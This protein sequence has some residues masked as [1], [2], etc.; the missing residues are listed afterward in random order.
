MHTLTAPLNPYKL[1]ITPTVAMP[2][3]NYLF[4]DQ[5]LAALANTTFKQ[6]VFYME[7]CESGSMF[8][9]LPNDTSIY[10]LTASNADE[11]SWGCYCP[12]ND[13]INGTSVGS[14]LGD[15]FS[16][17]WLENIDDAAEPTNINETLEV[18][19]NTLYVEVNLSHASQFGDASFRSV[20]A[21]A[22]FLAAG[23]AGAAGNNRLAAPR[24]P[25]PWAVAS[26][27]RATLLSL[28]T[29]AARGSARAAALL[30]AELDSVATAER[31]LARL[32]GGADALA[33]EAAAP[34]DAGFGAWA[35]YRAAVAAFAAAWGRFS[36][37]SLG[38]AKVLARRCAAA[39]AASAGNGGDGGD[40]VTDTVAADVAAACGA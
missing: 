32:L 39:A 36:D 37:S 19:F 17:D 25:A 24:A 22:A 5:L 7:A 6:M 9:A 20:E 31:A 40:A 3:G 11:S 23:R 27:R 13:T 21:V 35:C 29:R 18:Q 15:L 38:Y 26:A 30:S 4:A 1:T 28:E 12:P 8:E 14:C 34:L 16:V 2:S 33:R 10:A